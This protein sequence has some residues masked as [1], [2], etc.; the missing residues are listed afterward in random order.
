MADYL[1]VVLFSYLAGSIPNAIIIGKLWRGIDVRE[2]GS[3]NI[4]ATNVFRVLGAA[5]AIT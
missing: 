5:P 4:G 2:H 3:G 1:K